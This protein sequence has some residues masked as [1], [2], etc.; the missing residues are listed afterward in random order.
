MTFDGEA[1]AGG[2]GDGGDDAEGKAFA[3]EQR[4]L[5]DVE[6]DPGVVVAVWAGARWR[7]GR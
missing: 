2:R 1:V 4:T 3:L 7:A 6:L 5:L